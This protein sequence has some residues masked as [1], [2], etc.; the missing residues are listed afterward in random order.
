ME[1]RQVFCLWGCSGLITALIKRVERFPSLSFV[2]LRWL[3]KQ[4][5]QLFCDPKPAEQLPEPHVLEQIRTGCQAKQAPGLFPP[6]WA[7][8]RADWLPARRCRGAEPCRGDRGTARGETAGCWTC[9]S[10]RRGKAFQQRAAL[11]RTTGCYL[12]LQ[13]NRNTINVIFTKVHLVLSKLNSG[14]DDGAAFETPSSVL[15]WGIA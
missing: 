9:V 3:A 15:P 14:F 2:Q 12:R 1:I 10:G 5:H 8:L 7:P 11:Y 4:E 6:G 13:R